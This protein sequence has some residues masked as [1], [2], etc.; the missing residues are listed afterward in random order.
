MCNVYINLTDFI[1]L[2]RIAMPVYW[3]NTCLSERII[4]FAVLVEMI[5]AITEE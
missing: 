2:F 3:T 1:P 4:S 5:K